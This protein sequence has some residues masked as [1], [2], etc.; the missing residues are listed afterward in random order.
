MLPSFPIECAQHFDEIV[1]LRIGELQRLQDAREDE[2]RRVAV[3]DVARRVPGAH[4]HDVVVEKLLPD[5]T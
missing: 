3:H 4:V 1:F 5:L 2:R